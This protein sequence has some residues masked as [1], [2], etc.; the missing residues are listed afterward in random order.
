MKLTDS[1][2]FLVRRL[3]CSSLTVV[4]LLRLSCTNNM[5]DKLWSKNREEQEEDSDSLERF[6][7]FECSSSTKLRPLFFT[8]Y[9]VFQHRLGFEVV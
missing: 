9:L 6:F 1:L 3:C 4:V 7:G 5:L 2:G 8:S